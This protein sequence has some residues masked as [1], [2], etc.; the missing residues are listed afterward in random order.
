M[1]HLTPTVHI[2]L[3]AVHEDLGIFVYLV[4]EM[5][6]ENIRNTSQL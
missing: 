1:Q 5:H 6:F 3:V 4:E 2:G